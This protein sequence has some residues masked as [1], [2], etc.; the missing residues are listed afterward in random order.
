MSPKTRS[1]VDEKMPDESDE[2]TQHMMAW[3]ETIKA[4]AT[5]QLETTG[6][7][8]GEAD[9]G[10]LGQAQETLNKTEEFFHDRTIDEIDALKEMGDP[11]QSGCQYRWE[12]SHRTGRR[13]NRLRLSRV[14]VN[15]FVQDVRQL[16]E[17]FHIERL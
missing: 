14:E 9:V 7:M 3:L 6:K 1:L 10:A 17:L 5:S 16:A 15:S 11:G 4:R 2:I 12:N 8:T 13:R